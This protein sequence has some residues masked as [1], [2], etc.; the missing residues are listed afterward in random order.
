MIRENIKYIV[1]V[2][3]HSLKIIRLCEALIGDLSDWFHFVG[4]C[5]VFTEKGSQSIRYSTWKNEF[6]IFLRQETL[7]SK[8]YEE[9]YLKGIIIDICNVHFILEL[10]GSN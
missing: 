5:N 1:S 10:I 6:Q 9:I 3:R 2:R 8:I 4:T 7:W